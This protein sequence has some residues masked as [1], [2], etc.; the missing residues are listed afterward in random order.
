MS[1]AFFVVLFYFLLLLLTP[2]PMATNSAAMVAGA[3]RPLLES[4]SGDTVMFKPKRHGFV[5]G[6]VKNCMPK[7]FHHTSAP[8]RYINQHV[9]GS[10]VCSTGT[11][12][13]SP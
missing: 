5:H 9:F 10:A 12:V 11:D 13:A 6:N 2:P 7:G 3:T 1:C 4:K 8:S